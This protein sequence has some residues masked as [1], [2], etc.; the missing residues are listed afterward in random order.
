L[1]YLWGTEKKGAKTLKDL[2]RDLGPGWGE[3]DAGTDAKR[4]KGREG[5]GVTLS[6][7][8]LHQGGRRKRG[9]A[10]GGQASKGERLNWT[11]GRTRWEKER[12]RFVR[13]ME[14]WGGTRQA[15]KKE[16]KTWENLSR[17]GPTKR[18]GGIK[19][20]ERSGKGITTTKKVV[21]KEKNVTAEKKKVR[22]KRE[23]PLSFCRRRTGTML[24]E[25]NFWGTWAT[26]LEK[27]K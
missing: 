14:N 25:G 6:Q 26:D 4:S 16:K 22:A 15:Q 17:N 19:G 12:I 24:R 18:G 11:T 23:G 5:S 3:L 10:H 2:L 1:K 13:G 9:R 21:L 27:K 20:C 8:K 7:E